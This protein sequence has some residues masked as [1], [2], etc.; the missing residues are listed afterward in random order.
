MAWTP[1]LN[2]ICGRC[3]KPREGFVHVC[4]SNSTRKATPRPQFSFGTCPKCRKPQGNPLTHTC[5]PKSDFRRRRARHEKQARA[6]ARK[7][8][9]HD[10]QSCGDKDCQRSL[11]VAFRTG[12]K[13]GEADGFDRGWAAGFPAGQAACPLPHG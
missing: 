3:G 13:T 9:R 5:A 6:A 1:R 12:Y 4:R 11:C 2:V 7:R 8:D 10:Y